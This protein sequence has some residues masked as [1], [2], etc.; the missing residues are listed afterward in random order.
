MKFRIFSIAVCAALLTVPG[1]KD[2]DDSTP[3]LSGSVTYSALPAYVLY[4]DSFHREVSGVYAGGG[5]IPGYRLYD[6]ITAKSDTLRLEGQDGDVSFDYTVTKDTTGIFT[7]TV[8]AFC[9]GY[10]GLS[11][12][13]TITVVNPSL[14]AQGSLTGHPFGTGLTTFTDDSRDGSRYYTTTVGG[15]VW[16][17]QNL[18]YAA[19]GTPFSDAEAMS[20]IFGRYYTFDEAL[21][22]CPDGWHL[23]SDAEFISLAGGG[24]SHEKTSGGAAALK[25]SLS[26]NGS[27]M[28]PYSS[29]SI[30]ETNETLF[31]A[32]PV[33]Y[34]PADGQFNGYG[35]GAF[36]WTAD[37]LDATNSLVRYLKYDSDD[38]LAASMDR[39]F[40]ASVRCVK[41]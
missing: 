5:E 36:F 4:G 20:A 1:C 17:A 34:S 26:F 23:P 30:K 38:I 2:D 27:A 19:A 11:K 33:G 14:G 32:I 40:R 18:C 25:G 6:G 16:M 41:D 21:A 35:E 13:N 9:S 31:T 3:Y 7:V 24:T 8:Y 39:T 15:A 37:A 29:S 28:W 10:Y 22:A 12:S